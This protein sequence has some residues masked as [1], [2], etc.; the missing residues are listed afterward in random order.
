MSRKASSQ[1]GAIAT[2]ALKSSPRAKQSIEVGS[3]QELADFVSG[4]L[5]QLADPVRAIPM[6]AY[7]RTTQ[8][9][10]GVA[11][12][13]VAILIREALKLFPCPDQLTYEQ[14]VL[15]LWQLPH[16][17]EK[18]VAISYARQPKFFTMKSVP[19]YER[20]IREGAWWDLVDE[21]AS[22]LVGGVLANARPSMEPLLDGWILDPDLWIRR[23]A[24]LSQLRHKQ[25]TNEAQLFR[26]CLQLAPE[27][28]FF[29]RKAIG[30]ALRE[31][32]KTAPKAIMKFLKANRAKLSPLSQREGAKHLVREGFL[33]AN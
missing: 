24:L 16:R 3:P 10:H 15:V 9:F 33:S 11:K 6:A 29:I 17:E 13:Q 14:N 26:Y 18:Y 23:T 12:P 8:P 5:A 30:W 19:L 31:Y 28:E 25:E 27:R 2:T 22:Y 20:I 1:S 32:S 7:M 4:R 21:T